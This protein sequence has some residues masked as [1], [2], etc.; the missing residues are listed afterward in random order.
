M[1][2]IVP[3][4]DESHFAATYENRI[5][6]PQRNL[7]SWRTLRGTRRRRKSASALQSRRAP[8]QPIDAPVTRNSLFF[9]RV[10][11]LTT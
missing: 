10:T 9:W 2:R 8:P 11:S 6:R 7:L 3:G 4:C 5:F 1:R